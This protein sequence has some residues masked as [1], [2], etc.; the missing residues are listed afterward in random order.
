MHSSSKT[1][2]LEFLQDVN[3]VTIVIKETGQTIV[4]PTYSPTQDS[5]PSVLLP[6]PQKDRRISEKLHGSAY[7]NNAFRQSKNLSRVRDAVS[8]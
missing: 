6:M 4:S 5:S 1:I 7:G 8:R 3:D 2:Y